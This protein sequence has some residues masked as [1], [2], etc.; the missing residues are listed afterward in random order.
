MATSVHT[1]VDLT[2]RQADPI[3]VRRRCR[4]ERKMRQ[5]GTSPPSAMQRMRE[6]GCEDA[7]G[8]LPVVRPGL[9]APRHHAARGPTP[10]SASPGSVA[11]RRPSAQ[12]ARCIGTKLRRCPVC[13][14]GSAAVRLSTQHKGTD[15]GARAGAGARATSMCKTTAVALHFRREP[16]AARLNL[17]A[18]S[19]RN[20]SDPV[21]AP[22]RHRRGRCGRPRVGT[23]EPIFLSLGQ[24]P[25]G[26]CE[27][28]CVGRT[29]PAPAPAARTPHMRLDARPTAPHCRRNRSSAASTH[30]P[31]TMMLRGTNTR[32]AGADRRAAAG[33]PAAAHVAAVGARN[34]LASRGS[35]SGVAVR[36]GAAPRSQRLRVSAISAP[37]KT[38]A[39]VTFRGR[40]GERRARFR[41]GRGSI[42]LRAG[43]AG[44]LG[45]PPLTSPWEGGRPGRP[46]RTPSPVPTSPSNSYA[47][48]PAECIVAGVHV[49]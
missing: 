32:A 27:V 34:G 33:R 43:Y 21:W 14:D 8:W 6:Q 16:R 17:Q 29:A 36:S 20:D 45:R 5:R 3:D 41:V 7:G 23:A 30:S 4:G 24:R 38:D 13:G 48:R 49:D 42:H 39:K 44:R 9:L 1:E 18:T 22:Q 2:R 35:G 11:P 19:S 12:S 46:R 15:V 37:E 25:S 47:L 28:R 40:A 31:T 26:H 10:A